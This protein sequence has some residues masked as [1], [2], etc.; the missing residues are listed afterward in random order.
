[1]THEQLLSTARRLDGRLLRTS[2]GTE[3]KVEVIMDSLVFTPMSTRLPR[4]NGRLAT[5]MFVEHYN[6]TRSLRPVDYQNI[7]RNASYLVVLASEFDRNF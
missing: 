3:F 7:T 2:R 5:E 4:S 6:N 1:M